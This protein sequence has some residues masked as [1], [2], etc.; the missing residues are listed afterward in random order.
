M[1]LLFYC[2]L[3]LIPFSSFAAVDSP[4]K[5]AIIIDDLGNL[6]GEGLRVVEL[7]GPVVCSILP[8]TPFSVLLADAA[9]SA[10][11]E[12]ILHTPMQAL[13]PHRLGAGG[14][15]IDDDRASFVTTLTA[16][17]HAV[18]Y[19]Q[20]INNHM[21]SLLTQSPR[22]MDWVMQTIKPY[23]LFFIDSKTSGRSVAERVAKL[24]DVPTAG[25]D[26]FLDDVRTPEAVQAQFNLLL[27]MAK[28][29]GS[30]IA[31]GH[32]YAVTLDFLQ[33]ELPQLAKQGVVLVP[34]SQLLIEP[35][36][37]ASIKALKAIVV[38]PAVLA[39]ASP[40]VQNIFE[41]I[42]TGFCRVYPRLCKLGQ[43]SAF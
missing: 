38:K 19:I 1:R 32:P 30:A 41:K 12:I 39:A 34:V 37:R 15:W 18:P 24:D 31:I 4:P 42:S 13:F 9:H 40:P 35:T 28:L 26:V 20:G 17:L 14:L 36:K 29:H 21:G 7:P 11:K 2:L 8:Y 43:S 3:L 16:D 10:H 25:R 22:D 33:Q 6:R 5:I 23:N 27:A